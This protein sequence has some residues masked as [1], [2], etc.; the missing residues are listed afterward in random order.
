MRELDVEGDP[1]PRHPA[2]ANCSARR[3]RRGG[4]PLMRLRELLRL[5]HRPQLPEGT[6]R[7]GQ[8]RD[9]SDKPPLDDQDYGK[10]H[11]VRH[12]GSKQRTQEPRQTGDRPTGLYTAAPWFLRVSLG[13]KTMDHDRQSGEHSHRPK[14]GTQAS[15]DPQNQRRTRRGFPQRRHAGGDLREGWGT[16]LRFAQSGLFP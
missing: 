7:F 5:R 9:L 4:R 8:R 6:H 13:G 2:P 14:Y 16:L 15:S 12:R 11:P 1:Y 10:Q 3:A